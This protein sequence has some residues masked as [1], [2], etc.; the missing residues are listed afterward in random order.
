M[1]LATLC[2]V[3]HD[4]KTLM[5]HRVKKKNDMHQGKWNGLGGKLD[6]GESPE[7]CALREIEEECGLRAAHPL[8][9][10]VL[11]FPA[12]DEIED[13]YVFVFVVKEFEG[14]LHD[15][16]EGYLSWVPDAELLDLT[17]WEGDRIFLP[18]LDQPGF[19]SGKFIYDK[20]RLV[21]HYACFY[22]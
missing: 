18:W 3:K 17:L 16:S 22:Q 20:G 7:E 14:E 5:L 21:D 6:A 2:Y 4:G 15:T 13:W 8:L 12:F 10:G 9:K 11:T 19:F 1:K